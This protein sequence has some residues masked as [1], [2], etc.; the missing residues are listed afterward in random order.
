M[1]RDGTAELRARAHHAEA[2]LRMAEG[3]RAGAERALRAGLR[4]LDAFRASLG[5]TELRVHAAGHGGELARLGVRLAMERGDARAVLTWAERFRA[6]AVVPHPA[7]P[8]GD[9]AM[10]RDLAEL[11]QVVAAQAEAVAAG[12]DPADLRRR[13]AVLEESVRRGAR[14][15]GGTRRTGG[16]GPVPPAELGRA[17]GPA[18]LVEYLAVDGAL[19]AVVVAAGRVRLHRLGTVAEA[20][21]HVAALRHGLRRMAYGTRSVAA[22][23]DL[24]AA[25]AGRLDALLLRPLRL[26]GPLLVVPTGALH[27]LPWAALPSLAERPVCVAPSAALWHRAAVTAPPARAGAAV[28]VAG[29][30][31]P[32]ATAEVA[33]LARRSP[34]ARQ[35]T[36]RRAT[37]EAVLGALDGADLAHI[38]A[39]GQFRSDNPLFS[40]LRLVDG[41]L[42]V[43]DLERLA[44]PPRRVVLSA[45]ESGLSAVHPGDEL[46]G[47]TAAL[48]GLGATSLVASVVP[49]PDAATRPLMLRLYRH[50]RS[51]AGSAAA[52][53]RARRDL[54]GAGPAA[55]VAAAGFAC[56]GAG[57]A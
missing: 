19:H 8:A 56:F 49:V 24:V 20:E 26:D 12:A 15:T 33:A 39:H 30:G 2:L 18:A 3:D 4:V 55:R 29:P 51:G 10:A 41:P 35:L 46:L 37:A 27:A 17:L 11:R 43:Y 38:A 50:L 22:A 25:K 34:G 57:F 54:A 5:A 14:R 44:R 47:L 16:P 48:L 13:Q 21:D 53:A 23:G 9:P 32:H 40:A 36:G 45:C 31:L 42:T 28:F 7:R 6:R 1:R 52:L